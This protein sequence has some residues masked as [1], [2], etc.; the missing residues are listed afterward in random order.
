MQQL[1]DTYIFDALRTPVG[2]ADKGSLVS[3][4]ADDLA[5]QAVAALM[6]RSGV[7]T[8]SVTELVCGCGYPFGEQGY[9]VGRT[10]ALLARLPVGMP[11]Y[12]VS[13]LC[14][15]SL[16]ATRNAAH[17]IQ[18]NEE[19]LVL[20]CGLES[21]S[22]VGTDRH[23]REPNP[24]LDPG[25]PG[26]TIADIYLPMVQ[27][28]ENVARRC[29]ITRLEMDEF[30][31]QSQERAL[32]SQRDGFYA[33]EIGA[34]T[35]PDGS[36]VVLDDGPRPESTLETLGRLRPVLPGGLVTAG[37][38]CP[39]NDGAAALLVGSAQAGDTLGLR[40]RARIVASG[41]SALD[42]TI[43]GL[44][45]IDAVRQV[46]ARAEL[47]VSDIDVLE[48]NE[49]FAAQVIACARELGVDPHSTRLNP[50]GGAIALGHP[51]GMTG[52]RILT[53]L[54]NGLDACNGRYG[55]ATMCVGGGQ[56]QAM[57]IERDC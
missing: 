49:A 50:H 36:A 45:P 24:L 31:Q 37:N 2:R 16:Q 1:V 26:P 43:M 54:L 6:K 35:L 13:K 55:I 5:A 18:V 4:R 20:V 10:I 56:G 34:V 19:D 28:A 3:I 52:A 53:T 8:D 23:L 15:S 42:P 40:P 22:R 51:F 48:I 12:T 17:S 29:G 30:A 27:T 11:A 14:A 57:L 9:N 25:L 21:V 46:L 7:P 47:S 32:C 38:S 39:L 33:K 44:G 41:T